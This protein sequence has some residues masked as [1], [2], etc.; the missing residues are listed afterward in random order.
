[1][2][3]SFA[4]ITAASFILMTDGRIYVLESYTTLKRY[5]SNGTIDTLFT[6]VNIT[7]S[8]NDIVIAHQ[9]D[10]RVVIAGGFSAINNDILSLN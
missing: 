9:S 7:S 10:G 3:A 6:T 4:P 5:L 2:D 8:Y 1:V